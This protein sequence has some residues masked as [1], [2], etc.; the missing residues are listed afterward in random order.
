[1]PLGSIPK[2]ESTISPMS[3]WLLCFLITPII[4]WFISA[5]IEMEVIQYK[6]SSW[7]RTEELEPRTLNLVKAGL[8][9][10][11]ILDDKGK[12]WIWKNHKWNVTPSLDKYNAVF[13]AHVQ[14]VLSDDNVYAL[15]Y[16]GTL[17]SLVNSV[18]VEEKT[19]P[20]TSSL[21]SLAEHQSRI[22]VTGADESVWYKEPSTDSW[23]FHSYI[24]SKGGKANAEY[25]KSKELGKNANL[26]SD[27]GVHYKLKSYDS[28]LYAVG[29]KILRMENDSWVTI[30][31]QHSMESPE[32]LGKKDGKLWIYNNTTIDNVI[33]FASSI[34][35]A[36]FLI[37]SDFVT[38]K[39][40]HYFKKDYKNLFR[41]IDHTTL[42]GIRKEKF[43][44]SI[45][46]EF[47]EVAN[48]ND[49]VHQKFP[50]IPNDFL[51]INEA[52][53]L[54]D[55]TIVASAIVDKGI[56]SSAANYLAGVMGIIILI[57]FGSFWIAVY[58]ESKR[59]KTLRLRLNKQ[60]SE[61]GINQFQKKEDLLL[62]TQE[63]GNLYEVKTRIAEKL[64]SL[65]TKTVKTILILFSLAAIGILVGTVSSYFNLD[66]N[67]QSFLVLMFIIS[68]SIIYSLLV[69]ILTLVPL[70]R[71]DYES[72][73]RMA[74]FLCKL[75]FNGAEEISGSIKMFQGDLNTSDKLFSSYIATIN[76]ST[77]GTGDT[78]VSLCS[79]Y[80]RLKVWEGKFSEASNMLDKIANEAYSYREYLITCAELMLSTEKTQE[81]RR[82][83]EIAQSKNKFDQFF[84]KT[85]KIR[86]SGF[87]AL[88]LARE[89]SIEKAK[90]KLSDTLRLDKQKYGPES[91]HLL[92][93]AG[94]IYRLAREHQKSDEYFNAALTL[95]PEGFS[96]ILAKLLIQNRNLYIKDLGSEDLAYRAIGV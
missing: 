46:N 65:F 48:L 73:F 72:A 61:H 27:I 77:G 91:S 28:S 76:K 66:A 79:A 57:Q 82:L 68:T 47:V 41:K 51:H 90:K 74:S 9:E 50:K 4:T 85:Q 83:F 54:S 39:A 29:P 56:F 15:H 67:L 42:W 14:Y 95:D 21:R 6:D 44:F 70:R 58:F 52:M 43:I 3:I 49:E 45:E 71:F 96:G 12:F 86:E 78:I 36:P 88:L 16:N 53:L 80:A 5:T 92:V 81:A 32:I 35:E 26:S 59:K 84:A 22:W 34:S 94:E 24:D 38:K 8:R 63:K 30:I 11:G 89:G 23:V 2:N 60:H 87:E 55:E 31:N 7:V 37:S 1:M 64:S 19:P 62:R 17:F 18:W 20:E 69:Y 33:S 10:Y 40:D 25:Q 13:G 75:K 93:R